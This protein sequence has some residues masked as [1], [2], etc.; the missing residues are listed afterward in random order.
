M[1]ILITG[2]Y[3]QLGSELALSASGMDSYEVIPTDYDVLD[4]TDRDAVLGYIGKSKPD[5]VIN[6]AA[7]T[8]VDLAEKETGRARLLN[9]SGPAFLAESC[10]DSGAS[11]IHI[12]TDYVFSGNAWQPYVESSPTDPRSIYGLTKLEGEERVL[13][14]LPAA[15]IVRTSWLYSPF[16]HNFVRTMLRLGKERG[17]LRVVCDQIGTPTYG[18]DLAQALLHIVRLSGNGREDW[19]PGIY[20]FS[21][22]GVCSWY[23]FARAIFDLAGINCHV[24]PVETWEY[25]TAAQRPLYS[26]MNKRKI[27]TEFH[28]KIPY[29]KDSLQDCIKRL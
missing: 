19:K 24:E 7:Y 12:S 11:L 22:E 23:D 27:K 9:A 3:G 14:I 29:W 21:N 8:A 10:R 25:P 18:K 16:G 1:K 6:C 26:V 2:A 28:L 5:F 13:S 15:M 17:E 4:I 20:H